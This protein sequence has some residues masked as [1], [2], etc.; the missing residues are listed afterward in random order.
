MYSIAKVCLLH[1]ARKTARKGGKQY[2]LM[3]TEPGAFS[4][5]DLK[6]K[7]REMWDGVRNYQ[8]R[9]FMRDEMQEG[10][11]VLFYHSSTDTPGVVGIAAVC[12]APY[13]DPTAF[14]RRDPHY[15]PKSKKE[16]PTWYVVDVCF[17]KRFSKV[18]PLS[19]LRKEETLSGMPLLQRGQRLSVQ[20]V[21][22][23][24]FDHIMNMAK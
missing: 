7:K 5:D 1:M 6:K 22:K 23:K 19:M 9:N 20:P 8:A 11:L 2:W 3:K 4:I 17:K 12:S 13:P 15:D 21:D 16:K 24:H 14:D 18:L 10:D